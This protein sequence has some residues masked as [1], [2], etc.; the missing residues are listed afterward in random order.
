MDQPLIKIGFANS[1]LLSPINEG[2]AHYFSRLICYWCVRAWIF[3][4]LVLLLTSFRWAILTFLVWWTRFRPSIL[5]PSDVLSRGGQELIRGEGL[6]LTL[7]SPVQHPPVSSPSTVFH[8]KSRSWRPGT[9]PGGS[10]RVYTPERPP[11]LC[12][13]VGTSKR[14]A[15]CFECSSII[16]AQ[17]ETVFLFLSSRLFL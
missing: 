5:G 14:P 12:S 8:L 13:S 10:M 9:V 3:I 4:R 16:P 15:D 1:A 6:L 17:T 7:F 11:S 2:R